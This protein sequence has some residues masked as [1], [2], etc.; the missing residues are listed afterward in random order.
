MR[1]KFLA[2]AA[3]GVIVAA[4][5]G[6]IGAA[7]G[8]TLDGVTW[9][10]ASYLEDGAAVDVPEQVAATATFAN[11]TVSGTN[12]CNAYNGPY[13]ATGSSLTV[14]PLV[15][16]LMA[17]G[18]V[19]SALES[20]FMSRFQDAAS[21]TSTATQLTVYDQTG[22][23][24]MT[25]APQP[26]ITLGGTLWNVVSYNNG[27][28]ATVSVAIDSSISLAFGADGNVSGNATC[29]TY[30]GTYSAGEGTVT[31]GPLI[32]TRMACQSDELNEQ[33]GLYLAALEQSATYDITNGTLTIRD[34]G[35]A[36]QVIAQPLAAPAP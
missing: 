6:A 33:E 12:G 19:Q 9:Q 10:L 27:R 20:A 2:V 32:T 3:I 36:S 13:V 22:A 35:G 15:S 16:T 14:G 17:C 28:E 11:G 5:C 29:N 26:A 8:G 30:N 4:G 25:F 1:S 18:P 7:Q 24:T 34:S 23:A 21:Y 31:V